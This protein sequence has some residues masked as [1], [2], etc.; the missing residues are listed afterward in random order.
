M[1]LMMM[2]LKTCELVICFVLYNQIDSKF[3]LIKLIGVSCF[4]EEGSLF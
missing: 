1:P 4:G 2:N 3:H